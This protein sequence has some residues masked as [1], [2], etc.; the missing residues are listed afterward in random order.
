MD[1][2]TFDEITEA[3]ENP[4]KHMEVIGKNIVFNG[5]TINKDLHNALEAYR[6]GDMEKF[7]YDLGTALVLAVTPQ[8]DLFLF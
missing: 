7:G 3:A 1:W 6:A 4:S 8:D 2:T 5:V